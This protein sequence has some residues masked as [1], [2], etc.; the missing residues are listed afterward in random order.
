MKLKD[1][2]RECGEMGRWGRGDA[3]TRRWGDG[4]MARWGD[5]ERFGN[6]AGDETFFRRCINALGV[7]IVLW[8]GH[9]ARS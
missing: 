3:G 4:Q 2:N 9:L 7:L 6:S 8:N 1:R 5:G